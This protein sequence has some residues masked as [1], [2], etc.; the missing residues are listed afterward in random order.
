MVDLGR[1]MSEAY[2]VPGEEEIEDESRSSG[3]PLI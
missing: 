3:E 2:Q 1:W